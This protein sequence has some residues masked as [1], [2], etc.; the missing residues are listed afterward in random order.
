MIDISDGLIADL[1]H[2]CDASG[3]GAS[4]EWDLIPT[5][6]SIFD[7]TREQIQSFALSSGED[8]ELLFSSNSKK[9]SRIKSTP[10][11][12]IGEITSNVGIVELASRGKTI[13]LP[14]SGYRHF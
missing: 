2:L 8:F 9:L 5:D 4:I 3:V 7:F 12:R 6:E 10:V 11:T 1:H 13:S 14:R